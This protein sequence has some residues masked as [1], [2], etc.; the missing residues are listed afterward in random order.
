MKDRR[1]WLE[2][3]GGRRVARALHALLALVFFAA[4]LSACDR[5]T[6]RPKVATA[7]P[8]PVQTGEASYYARG[9]RGRLTASGEPHDPSALTAASPSLPLGSAAKVTNRENGRSVV[10][11]ID[12]RGPRAKDR[13]LDVS[14]KAADRLAFKGKGVAEVAVQPLKP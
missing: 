4:P 11:K 5:E 7:P 14:R 1:Y 12:D 13:I 6:N 9:L 3:A 2:F 10:V 8:K